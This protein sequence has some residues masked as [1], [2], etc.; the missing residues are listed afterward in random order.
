MAPARWVR[1]NSRTLS[2]VDAPAHEVGVRLPRVA[3]VVERRLHI[4]DVVG[5]AVAVELP[6]QL[7]LALVTPI[8]GADP[9]AGLLRHRGDR[10]TRIGDE[11]CPRGLEDA[12]VVPG[13]LGA[14]A[15]QRSG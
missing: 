11:D 8:Q 4:G 10:R 5:Q 12:L 3:L 2:G 13:R 15:A 9:D 7:L 6:Q 14:A 1:S